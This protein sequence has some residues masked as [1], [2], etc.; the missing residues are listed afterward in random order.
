MNSTESKKMFE[1]F[2]QLASVADW[3]TIK[4]TIKSQQVPLN[5]FGEVM[6]LLGVDVGQAFG[7]SIMKLLFE[8]KDLRD[9]AEFIYNDL[10]DQ[11]IFHVSEYLGG[12]QNTPEVECN[13]DGKPAENSAIYVFGNDAEGAK[14]LSY[15]L[16]YLQHEYSLGWDDLIMVISTALSN[17]GLLNPSDK[18]LQLFLLYVSKELTVDEEI[19][20]IEKII[21]VCDEEEKKEWTSYNK[22]LA[23]FFQLLTQSWNDIDKKHF[24]KNGPIVWKW[25]NDSIKQLNKFF[26]IN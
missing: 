4:N 14:K 21:G 15:V 25:G 12:F 17:W 26:K 1:V 13:I 24:F 2:E 3:E 23:Q 16:T 8:G 20:L 5:L 9:I 18:F 19:Q 22:K 10:C 11:D 7:Y 6:Y